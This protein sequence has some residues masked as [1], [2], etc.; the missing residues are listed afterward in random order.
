MSSKG[1]LP[2]FLPAKG[3]LFS[4]GQFLDGTFTTYFG[5]KQPV[6]PDVAYQPPT[7]WP[8]AGSLLRIPQV[9]WL[10]LG[11]NT[12]PVDFNS[13]G[14]GVNY[15]FYT[16][17]VLTQMRSI[18]AIFAEVKSTIESLRPNQTWVEIIDEYGDNYPALD[19]TLVNDS[20]Q[21]PWMFVPPTTDPFFATKF[22]RIWAGYAG[23]GQPD[24]SD[25]NLNSIYFGCDYNI[26]D[27]DS[28]SETTWFQIDT[29]LVATVVTNVIGS[30]AYQNSL[31]LVPVAFPLFPLY[32]VHFYAVDIDN[33]VMDNSAE[34]HAVHNN[35]NPA[36]A[37]E[38]N[39]EDAKANDGVL[40]TAKYF[41]TQAIVA[42]CEH[43]FSEYGFVYMG[44][45]SAI[46][47]NSIIQEI[48]NYFGFDPETGK[49]VG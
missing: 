29:G 13:T 42:Q 49:D 17:D 28:D 47:V 7:D 12:A 9:V 30:T 11:W 22:L 26:Q 32:A 19:Y 8:K 14:D 10:S 40:C 38:L 25:A 15:A 35:T 27:H 2:S 41:I 45:T 37:N 23:A 3:H 1:K 48:A 4:R 44:G 5:P 33:S 6:D 16:N 34:Q 36:L 31:S 20:N 18:A 39:D 46:T 43:D 21:V 24:N